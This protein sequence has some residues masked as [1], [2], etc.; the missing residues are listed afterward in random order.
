LA[1]ASALFVVLKFLFHVHFSLFGF[2]FWAAVVLSAGLVVLTMRAHEGK[3]VMSSQPAG[4]AATTEQAGS[5][6]P[7][8]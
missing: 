1:A 6:P 4:P 5:Q 3:P 2:G 7:P 8:A